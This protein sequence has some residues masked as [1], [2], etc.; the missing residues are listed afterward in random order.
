MDMNL[1]KK[2]LMRKKQYSLDKLFR[3]K[4]NFKE[5]FFFC[6]YL[7][8]INPVNES[9]TIINLETELSMKAHLLKLD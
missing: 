5:K 1:M 2:C 7:L 3:L 8:N 6:I 4:K 9:N